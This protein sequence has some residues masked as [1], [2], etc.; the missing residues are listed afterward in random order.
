VGAKEEPFE[1][2]ARKILEILKVADKRG[3]RKAVVEALGEIGK[4]QADGTFEP[5]D[6]PDES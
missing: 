2:Q 6:E 5:G 1:F 3:T 4:Q